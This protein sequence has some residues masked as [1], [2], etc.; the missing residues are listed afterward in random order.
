MLLKSINARFLIQ[1]R[2]PRSNAEEGYGQRSFWGRI[3]YRI[4]S[5]YFVQYRIVSI[6]FPHGHIMPSLVAYLDVIPAI[7]SRNFVAR[8]NRKCDT[9]TATLSHKQELANQ[10]SPHFSEQSCRD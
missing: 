5:R 8:Q 10:C 7:L 2:P 6:V 4:V 1:Y 3:S 9:C